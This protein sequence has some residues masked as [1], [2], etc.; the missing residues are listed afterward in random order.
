MVRKLR[1]A[2]P[3]EH[4]RGQGVQASKIESRGL[5][6]YD[7]DRS[8]QCSAGGCRWPAR[9]QTAAHTLAVR[10]LRA[11]AAPARE[12][13]KS[14][15]RPRRAQGGVA[16]HVKQVACTLE[17]AAASSQA[18][19]L[20]GLAIVTAPICL[21][22]SSLRSSC[23]LEQRARRSRRTASCTAYLRVVPGCSAVAV[24]HGRGRCVGNERI[25]ALQV[26]RRRL[27]RLHRRNAHRLW[28]LAWSH[29]PEAVPLRS[30]RRWLAA[31]LASRWLSPTTSRPCRTHANLQIVS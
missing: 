15:R 29:A 12:E 17:V 28:G 23:G 14:P 6:R 25:P 5:F 10:L 13:L 2:F 27:H 20:R 16:E 24:A 3:K 31:L 7:P 26:R 30:G 1:P 8:S 18:T 21:T 22:A 11:A 4:G 19:R 9:G